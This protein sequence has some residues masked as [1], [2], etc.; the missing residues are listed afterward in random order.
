MSKINSM[1]TNLA[2]FYGRHS[3]FSALG[4]LSTYSRSSLFEKQSNATVGNLMDTMILETLRQSFPL[5][6]LAALSSVAATMQDRV[7]EKGEWAVV[8]QATSDKLTKTSAELETWEML[9][10]L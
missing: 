2:R 6:S 7:D 9:F 3:L 1:F 8:A 10:L 4:T 5:Y